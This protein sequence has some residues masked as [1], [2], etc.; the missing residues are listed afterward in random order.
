MFSDVDAKYMVLSLISST[1]KFQK[2]R[3]VCLPFELLRIPNNFLEVI[4]GN[5]GSKFYKL[6]PENYMQSS[7]VS[8]IYSLF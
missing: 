2:G 6:P 7:F 4:R 3:A 1:T 5:T 8:Q